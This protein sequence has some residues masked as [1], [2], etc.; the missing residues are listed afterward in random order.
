MGKCFSLVAGTMRLPIA[1][2]ARKGHRHGAVVQQEIRRSDAYLYGLVGKV[3]L[4]K[5]YTYILLFGKR[6]VKYPDFKRRRLTS[7]VDMALP[8]A[9]K[10]ITCHFQVIPVD[11]GCGMCREPAR[12]EIEETFGL[13]KA[14]GRKQQDGFKVEAIAMGKVRYGRIESKKALTNVLEGIIPVYKYTSLPELNA[15]LRQYNVLADRGSENSKVFKGRGL[16]YRI[17]DEN[18][19]PIGVPIKAS[20]FYTKPTLKALEGNFAVNEPLRLRH[21]SRIKNAIDLAVFGKVNSISGLV[22][23][24]NKE[25]IN[26]VLRLSPEGILYGITYI[27]HRTKCVFNGSALGKQYSA[28]AIVQRCTME[29]TQLRE[30]KLGE[31][32]MAKVLSGQG[33][34][35]PPVASVGGNTPYTKQ[36]NTGSS[37]LSKALDTIIGT[38]NTLDY[39]PGQFKRKKKK[40]KRGGTK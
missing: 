30:N 38:E 19:K 14:Q 5:P 18:G 7:K 40:K 35:I 17:L 36:G 3:Q 27:D 2:S 37:E 22:A 11:I 13:V 9:R 31:A 10:V 8:C 24:L 21:K 28:K 26:T 16:V 25:G 6:R 23:A 1:Y 12:K 15:V 33:R 39:V 32:A 34:G 20:D 4:L 29:G